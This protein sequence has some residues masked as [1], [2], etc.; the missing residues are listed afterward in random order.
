MKIFI[1]MDAFHASKT[2]NFNSTYNQILA[3]ETGKI[4]CIHMF[5][6]WKQF[7]L[8][9]TDPISLILFIYNKFKCWTDAQLKVV[10]K[11][12]AFFL[13]AEM[14]TN[15]MQSANAALLSHHDV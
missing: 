15:K 1:A 9:G 6:E 2:T 12:I 10:G 7:K 8:I 5:V 3:I 13:N 11:A 14:H 4:S